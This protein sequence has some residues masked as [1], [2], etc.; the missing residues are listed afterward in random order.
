MVRVVGTSHD[1]G[2]GHPQDVGTGDTIPTPQTHRMPHEFRA[3]SPPLGN[4]SLSSDPPDVLATIIRL[5]MTSTDSD[6]VVSLIQ[7]EPE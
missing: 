5:L 3:H 1:R 2:V 7:P 6:A 4:P